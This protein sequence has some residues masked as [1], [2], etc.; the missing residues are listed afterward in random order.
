MGRPAALGQAAEDPWAITFDQAL[1]RSRR[2]RVSG[3]VRVSVPS[4]SEVAQS[5]PTLR[6]RG[7]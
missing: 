1:T 2:A 7:L 5:F 3:C 6:S 4:V